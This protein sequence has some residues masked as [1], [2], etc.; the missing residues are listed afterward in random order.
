MTN[1]EEDDFAQSRPS[2]ALQ[3]DCSPSRVLRADA[4]ACRA[5]FSAYALD[6]VVYE[7][8][9]RIVLRSMDVKG[10]LERDDVRKELTKRKLC[11]EVDYSK[12]EHVCGP[13]ETPAAFEIED[14][15]RGLRPGG[16]RPSQKRTRASRRL[17]PDRG[18]GG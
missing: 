16:P 9:H 12:V 10:L 7:R 4:D 11:G 18:S 6:N 5:A 3:A 8:A 15:T 17:S 13:L 1:L 14:I 2:A